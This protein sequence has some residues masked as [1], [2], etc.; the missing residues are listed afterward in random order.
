MTKYHRFKNEW[1]ETLEVEVPKEIP[2]E[3]ITVE[4]KNLT[5]SDM[6]DYSKHLTPDSIGKN[7]PVKPWQSALGLIILIALG[8][9]LRQA[10]LIEFHV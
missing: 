5:L 2:P 10:I 7:K 8:M 3:G 1:G 9:I 6:P 4:A